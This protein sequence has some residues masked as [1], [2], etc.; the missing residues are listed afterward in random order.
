[1]LLGLLS[2]TMMTLNNWH[3]LT[4]I[5]LRGS[6]FLIWFFYFYFFFYFFFF[7]FKIVLSQLC[8]ILMSNLLSKQDNK[9]A[10]E[11]GE[12]KALVV[13][14]S[15][16][17]ASYATMFFREIMKEKNEVVVGLQERRK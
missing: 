15:L 1:M 14:F 17:S 4:L 6:S 10:R 7:F 8:F 16:P 5:F 9:V 13:G 2:N 12:K 3:P 11:E